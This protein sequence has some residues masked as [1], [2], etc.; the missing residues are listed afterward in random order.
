MTGAGSR[1][2]DE[3][4]GAR[5]QPAGRRSLIGTGRRRRRILLTPFLAA[6][7]GWLGWHIGEALWLHVVLG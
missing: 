7:G 5:P 6:A 3:A 2:D 1:A 4:D